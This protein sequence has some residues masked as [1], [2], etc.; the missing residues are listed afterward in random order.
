MSGVSQSQADAFEA[1]IA[2]P[3]IDRTTL[4]LFAGASGDHNPIHIDIDFARAAGLDD[5]FAQGMLVMGRMGSLL[6]TLAPPEQ[7]AAFEARFVAITRLG[8]RLTIAARREPPAAG[9]APDTVRLSLNASDQNGE[10][11]VV[12]SATLIG[13]EGPNHEA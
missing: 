7:I 2:F 4:A 10:V 13:M 6:A 11:K 1:S 3:P 12:A 9:D 5:V 8:D